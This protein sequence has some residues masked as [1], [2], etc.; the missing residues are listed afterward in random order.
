M[1]AVCFGGF[2]YIY[3]LKVMPFLMDSYLIRTIV[4]STANC[5]IPSARLK[6]LLG[7]AE[8]VSNLKT[9]QKPLAKWHAGE[10]SQNC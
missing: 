9:I 1:G 6:K 5:L 3:R 8:L 7:G 10:S 4:K 2:N